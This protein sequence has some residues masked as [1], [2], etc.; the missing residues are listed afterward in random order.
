MNRLITKEY[1]QMYKKHIERC[2]VLL[3]S[4]VMQVKST[5]R[6]NFTP[7]KMAKIKK[8]DGCFL[9]AQVK[10]PSSSVLWLRL[11]LWC[12]FD[13]WPG[14]FHIAGLVKTNKQTNPTDTPKQW[15]GM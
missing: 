7:T 13:P 1:L 14:N 6:Y 2:S 5:K 3:V 10:E 9:L 8:I 11:L 4:R 15:A 12:R